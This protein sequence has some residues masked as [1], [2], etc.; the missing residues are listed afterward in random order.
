MERFDSTKSSERN[1]FKKI[2]AIERP[3]F[4]GRLG[5]A[6]LGLGGLGATL[7][8]TAAGDSE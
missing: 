1:P 3:L 7:E 2:G 5:C 6:G 8:T 4:G